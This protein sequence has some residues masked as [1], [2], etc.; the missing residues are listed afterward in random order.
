LPQLIVPVFG[1]T[2]AVTTA[3]SSGV[4]LTGLTPI[5]IVVGTGA[6][7]ADNDVPRT[8]PT[9]IAESIKRRM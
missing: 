7:S 5:V 1:V 2:V 4:I 6:A 9:V 3:V 8:I